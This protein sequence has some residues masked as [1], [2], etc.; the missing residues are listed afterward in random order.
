MPGAILCRQ[1]VLS[2]CSSNKNITGRSEKHKQ[3]HNQRQSS[4]QPASQ[5]D[6]SCD[7][8]GYGG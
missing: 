6:G 3:A 1:C 7:V 2:S 8:D 4:N 5:D